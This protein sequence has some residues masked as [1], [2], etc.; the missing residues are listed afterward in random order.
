MGRQSK[1][2]LLL[3]VGHGHLGGTLVDLLLIPRSEGRRGSPSD[4]RQ[5]WQG[6]GLA[7]CFSPTS[8]TSWSTR[9][10]T[11]LQVQD[12]VGPFQNT[13]LQDHCVLGTAGHRLNV[14]VTTTLP[15]GARSGGW[16]AAE[17][18]TALGGHPPKYWETV[19]AVD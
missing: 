17:G 15:M 7:P 18:C 10:Q 19:G 6:T 11:Q 5:S 12:S 3:G 8:Y 1:N 9:A 16:R 13:G 2:W 4:S 14:G